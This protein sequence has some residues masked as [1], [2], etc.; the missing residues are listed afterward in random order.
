MNTKI[1]CLIFG[2]F[3]K[4]PPGFRCRSLLFRTVN[5][6]FLYVKSE[7]PIIFTAMIKISYISNQALGKDGRGI[8]EFAVHPV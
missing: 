3:A 1:Q 7:I 2:L 4:L 5:K 6:E 8:G